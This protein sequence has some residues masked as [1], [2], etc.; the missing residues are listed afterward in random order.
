MNQHL[1][2]EIDQAMAK[3]IAL[4]SSIE[5]QK[6]NS[7]PFEGS[8]TAG[9]LAKHMILSIGGAVQLMNGPFK[10]TDRKPD[11]HV[12]EIEASFLNFNIKMESPEFIRP[13]KITYSKKDLVHSLEQIKEELNSALQSVDM[14]QTCILYELPVLGYLTRLEA[15][16]FVRAHTLRH[17]HQL[18]K[19]IHSLQQKDMQT[20]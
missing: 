12:A 18:E 14:T 6:I 2:N 19:I 1:K 5:D 11:Q 15:A 16:A 10:E 13:P 4:L 9:Q 8:W 7:V 20:A 17:I 3:L